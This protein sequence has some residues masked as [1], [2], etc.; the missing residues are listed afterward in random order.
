MVKN[1]LHGTM[2]RK[3]KKIRRILFT[4]AMNVI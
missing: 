4:I 3:S 1:K 2:D